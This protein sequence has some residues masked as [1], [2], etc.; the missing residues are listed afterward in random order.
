MLSDFFRI[1]LPY[2]LAKNDKGEWFAFN[3]EYLPIGFNDLNLKKSDFFDY[4]IYTKYKNISE[5]VL[6]NVAISEKSIRRNEKGEIDK[7]WLYDDSTNPLSID[8]KEAWENY[9][10]KLKKLSKLKIQ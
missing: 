3:R 2:G 10:N 5:K 9:F 1:N 4:P 7:I 6:S 8:K